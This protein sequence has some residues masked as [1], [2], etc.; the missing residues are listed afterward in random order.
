MT[1]QHSELHF[2]SFLIERSFINI[3]WYFGKTQINSVILQI[4]NQIEN[5]IENWAI[6]NL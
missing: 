2:L 1:G 6:C 3:N 5:Q 4:K